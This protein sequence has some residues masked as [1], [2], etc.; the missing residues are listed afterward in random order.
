[1]ATPTRPGEGDGGGGGDE[2][3][4]EAVPPRRGRAAVAIPIANLIYALAL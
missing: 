2:A 3:A 1:M 4:A